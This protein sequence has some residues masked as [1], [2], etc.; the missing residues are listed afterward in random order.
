MKCRVKQA[1]EESEAQEAP[2]VE[3]D[4][5]ELLRA[6]K[7]LIRQAQKEEFDSE[8]KELRRESKVTR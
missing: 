3:L 8:I 2:R 4:P 5:D 7:L 1:S 6:E